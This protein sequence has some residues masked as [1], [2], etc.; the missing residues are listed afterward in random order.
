MVDAINAQYGWPTIA[1]AEEMKER[2]DGHL[3]LHMFNH[4]LSKPT[5]YK[6]PGAILFGVIRATRSLE[7]IRA[8][9]AAVGGDVLSQDEKDEL[10]LGKMEKAVY[11][12]NRLS[13]ELKTGKRSRK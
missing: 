13:K 2:P 3:S 11:E 4:Y 9:A 5:D 7:P 12:M 8:I 6:M 10:L 1:Q